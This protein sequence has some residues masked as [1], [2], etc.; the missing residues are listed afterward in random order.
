MSSYKKN[1]CF[2]CVRPITPYEP[3]VHFH[4]P[5]CG[6]VTIWRCE[7]CRE[8]GNSFR[9]LKCDFEGP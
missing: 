8:S 6:D 5:Q 4:C 1:I 9:C 7:R 2:G 3:S